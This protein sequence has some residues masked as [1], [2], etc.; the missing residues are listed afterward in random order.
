MCNSSLEKIWSVR[1][2]KELE[3]ILYNHDPNHEKRKYLVHFL[4]YAGYEDDV[5]ARI[6]KEKNKWRDYNEKI[7]WKQIRSLKTGEKGRKANAKYRVGATAPIFVFY[8]KGWSRWICIVH[9][10]LKEISLWIRGEG[11]LG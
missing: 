9:P 3:D 1:K 11:V 5:L 4:R 10:V 8:P 2:R 7:T 6:I